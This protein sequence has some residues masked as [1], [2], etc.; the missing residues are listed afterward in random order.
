MKS[1]KTVLLVLF[2]GSCHS[3]FSQV[4]L[5]IKFGSNYNYNG[6]SS[7]S[8]NLSIDNAVS[9]SGGALI[10]I[11]AKKL[12]FQGEGLLVGHKGTIA[13]GATSGKLDFISFDVPLLIGY[14]LLDL[15]VVKVRL[16]AGLI[17]SFYVGN[18]GDLKNANFEDAYYSATGGISLDVPYFYSTYVIKVLLAITINCKI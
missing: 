3:V 17:P 16:N 13:N 10:R 18:L 6:I 2:L 12:S 15:K 5:G 14:K 8:L 7:D 4:N 9:F 1:I 11:K